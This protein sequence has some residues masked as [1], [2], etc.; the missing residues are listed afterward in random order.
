MCDHHDM[1]LKV[2]PKAYP[3]ARTNILTIKY[4]VLNL[5]IIVGLVT[6]L[7]EWLVLVFH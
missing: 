2:A 4:Y 3:D 5:I 1:G 7:Q 6:F